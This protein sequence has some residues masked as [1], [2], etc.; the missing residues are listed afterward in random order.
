MFESDF[1]RHVSPH[2]RAAMD[3]LRDPQAVWDIFRDPQTVREMERLSAVK[4]PAVEAVSAKLLTLGDWVREKDAKRIFGKIAQYIMEASGY[5]IASKGVETP[6]D[7]L[8][9]KGSRY[10][11]KNRQEEFEAEGMMQSCA[12]SMRRSRAGCATKRRGAGARSKLKC[13]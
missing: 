7:P 4:R 1:Q 6:Q 3:R 13:C 8:F 2:L 5:A 12:A 10:Q 11:R 9:R